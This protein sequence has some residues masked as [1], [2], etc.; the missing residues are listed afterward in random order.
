MSLQNVLH[1]WNELHNSSV[2]KAPLQAASRMNTQV[3]EWLGNRTEH[4][5]YV[6]QM[7]DKDCA[8]L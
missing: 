8:Y 1:F 6:F 5:Q 7:E 3:N 2:Q 4:R